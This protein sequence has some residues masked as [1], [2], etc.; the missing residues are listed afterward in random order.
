MTKIKVFTVYTHRIG[1]TTNRVD[2][3]KSMAM[4][5]AF[6]EQV[7]QNN[8]WKVVH[9]DSGWIEIHESIQQA[10]NNMDNLS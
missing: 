6:A 2:N 7:K 9:I 1:T 5:K 3:F 4:A 8:I 10:I